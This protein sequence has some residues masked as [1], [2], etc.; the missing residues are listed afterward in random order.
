MK[1]YIVMKEIEF[2]GDGIVSVHSTEALADKTT[3]ELNICNKNH[4]VEEYEVEE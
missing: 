4:Y 3:T 1:V 2:Y